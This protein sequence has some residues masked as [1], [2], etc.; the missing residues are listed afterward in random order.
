MRSIP[1]KVVCLVISIC[2]PF[3][4]PSVSGELTIIFDNGQARP[5]ADFLG[6]L[7]RT[8]DN[9]D[10]EAN[11]NKQLGAANIE[12][13]LPIRSVG[14]TPGKVTAR[15]HNVPFARAFFLIGSDEWSKRWLLE[16]REKL[17]DIGAVG[18]LVQ[19]T[20]IEDLQDVARLAD[21][22]PVTPASG[23]DIANAI[24]IDHYPVGISAGRLWQ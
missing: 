21:R 20:T 3:A 16:H 15:A 19:A 23:S 5:L 22:L 18:M 14:L 8:K 24:G 10:R 12:L 6:P 7:E 2:L 4:A 11:K 17:K 1:K 13:L 9:N